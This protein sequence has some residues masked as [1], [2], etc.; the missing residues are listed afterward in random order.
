MTLFKQFALLLV[1]FVVVGCA[2]EPGFGSPTP[3][4]ARI[5][6]PFKIPN[7]NAETYSAILAK[8]S[9]RV[10]LVSGAG[11]GGL[12]AALALHKTKHFDHII[13][14]EKRAQFERNNTL[15]V[16][17]MAYPMLKELGVAEQFK[18]EATFS[19][20]FRLFE[21]SNA[22][23][24]LRGGC[25]SI[26]ESIDYEKS[27]NDIMKDDLWPPYFIDIREL[28]LLLAKEAISIPDV[29]LIHGEIEL[30]HDDSENKA[31]SV[32][33]KSSSASYGDFVVLR[34]KL[35]VIAE[36][37][38]SIA[39]NKLNIKMIRSAKLEDQHWCSGLVSLSGI[40]NKADM[41]GHISI[42]ADR[43]N[44]S[45]SFGIFRPRSGDL[46]IN[47]KIKNEHAAQ[48]SS[49]ACLKRNAYALLTHEASHLKIN[50]PASKE[51]IVVPPKQA[52][53]LD[54][55]P[56]RA[57]RFHDGTN[58]VLFGDTAAGWTPI[59]GIGGTFALSL[60]PHALMTLVRHLSGSTAEREAALQVYNQRVTEII[61]FW[62]FA[63][64]D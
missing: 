4:L 24:E 14:V 36:G 15:T 3:G 48:E 51:N 5:N 9:E 28:Q 18:K 35:I 23:L 13:V 44:K 27:V 37:T 16:Q 34:P 17:P 6:V 59:G 1:V 47:G 7:V 39:R 50:I 12:A 32:K 58:V 31:R 61:D 52:V 8:N 29:A 11:P 57:E 21:K 62:H 56:V 54:L 46:F 63:R 53:L 40:W 55:E 43:D 2:K 25:P 26:P 30:L 20:Q 64:K 22:K 49:E 33:V 38:R 60:Y 19:P 45:F 42:V 41:F 10:A